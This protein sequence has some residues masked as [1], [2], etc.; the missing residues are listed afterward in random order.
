[1]INCQSQEKQQEEQQ[2]LNAAEEEKQKLFVEQLEQQRIAEEK[3]R[4]QMAQQLKDMLF[5]P[6]QLVIKK[7][8]SIIKSALTAA[9]LPEPLKQIQQCLDNLEK[10]NHE[11]DE[12]AP[13]FDSWNHF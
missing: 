13:D 3:K 6:S 11:E 2:R 9:I 7:Q 5:K 12:L 8:L 1:M 10:K 4:Q